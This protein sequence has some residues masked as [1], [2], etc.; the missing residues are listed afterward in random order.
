[1]APARGEIPA[2]R[3]IHEHAWA[4]SWL[5][6]AGV[7]LRVGG[8]T[9]VCDPVLSRRIGV[10]IGPIVLG[11]E[12]LVPP[13]LAADRLPPIDL[14]LISHAHYDHLDRPTL[15]RLASG[16]TTVV[17]ARRTRR[18]I[19]RGFGRVVELDWGQS[20]VFAGVRICAIEPTH[21][22]ARAGVDRRRG[23]NSYLIRSDEQRI[24]FAGDT[25]RT[26]AFATLGPV[27]MA[28]F[29]IGAYDPWEHAHAMPEQVWDM[30][31]SCAGR[32]LLPVHH[33]TF[34]LS[35]EHVDEPLE[36]LLTAAGADRGRVIITA[37][38][39]LWTPQGTA[40]LAS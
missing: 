14:V 5:G 18:L 24:L 19:P 1:V 3:G 27:E 9:I 22:G 34:E 21:W 32:R 25:A 29:G 2:L 38:G 15:A 23:F 20:E 39:Q 40:R 12:R 31:V 10:R 28:I 30:F 7:L 6:H 37:P 8:S 36:R 11:P 4:A 17:T 16:R 35:E 33:S 13:P 26:D